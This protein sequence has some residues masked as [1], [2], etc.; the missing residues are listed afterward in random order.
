MTWGFILV[1]LCL[2]W[3]VGWG[4]CVG[5]LI[6]RAHPPPAGSGE[7]RNDDFAQFQTR[8]DSIEQ[9][10]QYPVLISDVETCGSRAWRCSM[11]RLITKILVNSALLA[12]LVAAESAYAQTREVFDGHG[13]PATADDSCQTGKYG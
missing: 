2:L 4:C 12:T 11:K 7:W 1:P 8:Y 10:A 9:T 5:E 13:A 6:L 3:V